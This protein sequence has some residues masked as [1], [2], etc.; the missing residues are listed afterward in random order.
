MP[1]GA[2]PFA[3][4]LEGPLELY[5]C[6]HCGSQEVEPHHASDLR[7][8]TCQELTTPERW[9]AWC[10]AHGIDL[11]LGPF[12]QAIKDVKEAS[13]LLFDLK[14]SRALFLG[15]AKRPWRERMLRENRALRDRYRTL[16]DPR[17]HVISAAD[18]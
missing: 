5:G 15:P 13:G 6:G 1:D 9:V 10:E 7:C 3:F 17:F 16:T 2:A 4:D 14:R 12:L 18:L 11:A 8:R